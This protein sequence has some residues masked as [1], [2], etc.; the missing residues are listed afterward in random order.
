MKRSR[1]RAWEKVWNSNPLWG[2]G[3]L[4]ND[5]SLSR[6]SEDMSWLDGNG[7]KGC[8]VGWISS[9]LPINYLVQLMSGSQKVCIMHSYLGIV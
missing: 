3:K 8:S 2:N 4:E 7:R 5:A 6:F 1:N 9:F